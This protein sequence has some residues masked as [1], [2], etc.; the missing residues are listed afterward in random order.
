LAN[1]SWVGS[2][3]N[4]LK[5][6]SDN[7]GFS[8]NPVPSHEQVKQNF[9]VALFFLWKI[10]GYLQILV[11]LIH[12]KVHDCIKEYQTIPFLTEYLQLFLANCTSPVA[13]E[14][15]T[16]QVQDVD[17]STAHW[18]KFTFWQPR[19]SF[20]Y[21]AATRYNYFFFRQKNLMI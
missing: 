16:A 11:W 17:F 10:L 18:A 19:K 1:N 9:K 2:T 4:F 14:N 7:T 20:F 12:T 5:I 15:I 8:L 6:P 21:K 13:I 3:A